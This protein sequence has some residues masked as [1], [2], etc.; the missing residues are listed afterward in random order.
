MK[1]RP[2]CVFIALCLLSTLLATPSVSASDFLAAAEYAQETGFL[3]VPPDAYYA[4]A[5]KWAVARGVTNG[6]TATTFS[7]GD[8]CTR[9]HVVTFLWR[10]KGEPSAS[11]NSSLADRFPRGYY[12]DAVAWADSAGILSGT[13][14]AFTPSAPCPRADIVTY[15]YR[16]QVSA[17]V[18]TAAATP[19]PSPMPASPSIAIP[20]PTP[21]LSPTSAPSL[22]EMRNEVLRLVNE[23]RAE[24]GVSALELGRALCEAA[25]V[26]AEELTE[27]FAHTRPDGSS[28]FTVLGQYGISYMAAGENIAA[29]QKTP[30]SVMQSWMN[31]PGHRANILSESFG[32]LGIGISYAPD[33]YGIYWCQLFTD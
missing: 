22:E 25:Q 6:T 32:T 27:E 18:P 20:S 33:S 23:A 8:P 1:R 30:A 2:F 13:S 3:D 16:D 15:L 7:P 31:S 9:A 19:I 26:R 12:T 10:S 17:P 11:G 21:M 29:G 14:E 4:D 5:V 24:N 28:C